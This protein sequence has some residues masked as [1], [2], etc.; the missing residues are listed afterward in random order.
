[1][2]DE[3]P[4][5]PPS[6]ATTRTALHLVAEH[7]VAPARTAATG[8]EIALE[9]RPGGFGT[10]ELPH[11]GWVGVAGDRLV[12]VDP[13]GTRHEQGLT[14][15]PTAAEFVGL[16]SPAVTAALD[17][18]PA[19]AQVVAAVFTFADAALT[20]L[21]SEAGAAEAASPVRLWPEHFDL[22]YEQGD[23]AAG[24]RV[25][26][27]VSPGDDEHAEPYA[28]VGPWTPPPPGPLW[29]A[30]AFPGAELS[31]GELRATADPAATVLAFFRARRDAVRRDP[32]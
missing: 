16:P 7:I 23:E 31:Y 25:G 26:F 20:A 3:L 10:P 24:L 6:Y 32:A 18:D 9:A 11:G 13:D 30:T 17:I 4:P 8:N 22:A 19:A 28:Y 15:L 5:V 27:G 12:R 29:N 14:T 1:M 21:R 2:T